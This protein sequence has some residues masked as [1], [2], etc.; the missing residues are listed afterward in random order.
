M[1]SEPPNRMDHLSFSA[2]VVTSPHSEPPR[3]SALSELLPSSDIVSIM[4]ASRSMAGE[5]MTRARRI[6]D[7]ISVIFLYISILLLFRLM[8]CSCVYPKL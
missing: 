3:E 5:V 1:A 4:R 2:D 8:F 6:R 7:E